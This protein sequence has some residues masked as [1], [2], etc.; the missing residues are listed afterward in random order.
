VNR[1]AKT[2]FRRIAVFISITVTLP[3]YET[4]LYYALVTGDSP[5]R[6]LI[7]YAQILSAGI[8]GGLLIFFSMVVD[9]DS[10]RSVLL[11]LLKKIEDLRKKIR[12][13]LALLLFLI[14]AL[15]LIVSIFQ[16]VPQ[17]VK[18]LL[19][20]KYTEGIILVGLWLLISL[21]SFFIS[22]ILASLGEEKPDLYGVMRGW[23]LSILVSLPF[24]FLLTIVSW[25]IINPSR[26]TGELRFSFFFGFT[27]DL[28][29]L[30]IIAELLFV[31]MF[32]LAMFGRLVDVFHS[33]SGYIQFLVICAIIAILAIWAEFNFL[34]SNTIKEVYPQEWQ[35]D[36]TTAHVFI[37]DIFLLLFP[38][39]LLLIW[40]LRRAALELRG[41]S[42]P[43][44]KHE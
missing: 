44:N 21:L 16:G 27:K 26:L 22:R 9:R 31:S 8:A 23:S 32:K 3:F 28:L 20:G 7:F 1:S 29:L 14:P 35:R 25:Y 30:W 39:A 6:P 18:D 19:T 5:N 17:P 43:S 2:N 38:I 4:V 40:V 37:R 36:I 12:Q 24:Y 15:F 34:S 33:I 13:S 41:Q 10:L 11:P 42:G